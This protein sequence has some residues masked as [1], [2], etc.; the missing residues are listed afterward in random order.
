MPTTIRPATA[1]DVPILSAMEAA[2][3][4]EPW[5]E[6]AV[7]AHLAGEHHFAAVALTEAGEVAG[8]LFGLVLSGEAELLR[9]A[10]LPAH[11][12]R[13][14][15]FHLVDA[16]LLHLAGQDV[17]T[18]FLEVRESNSAAIGLY[19]EHGFTAV[20]RRKAYYR[21]PTEDAIVMRYERK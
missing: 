14:I 11:R 6:A 10:V 3:F 16:F 18:C 9:V 4:S 1:G 13:G 2:T 7:A 20:G 12:H 15:G 17:R 5:S 21:K 19:E 8:Y